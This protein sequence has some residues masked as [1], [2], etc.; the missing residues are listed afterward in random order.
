MKKRN[1]PVQE[2][3]NNLYVTLAGEKLVKVEA[4]KELFLAQGKSLNR[5]MAD[6][7]EKHKRPSHVES[8]Q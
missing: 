8:V 6:A 3:I 7:L 5:A 1:L 4:S 2:Q